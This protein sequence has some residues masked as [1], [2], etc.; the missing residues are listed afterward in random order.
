[1][2]TKI[3]QKEFLNEHIASLSPAKRALLEFKLRQS[4]PKPVAGASI[5]RRTRHSPAPLSF[6]Q[7]RLWFLTQLEPDS[8]A[9]NMSLVRRLSGN[10][11]VAALQQALSEIV[12]RHESLRTRFEDLDGIPQQVIDEPQE[13]S[14]KLVDLTGTAATERMA[15][16]QRLAREELRRPFELSRE[17]GLR[18]QLLRL[19]ETEHILLLTMHHIVSD[20]W[21]LGVLFGEL[22]RL[23]EAYTRNEA[24]PL[25]ELRLQYAD[26][27]VWQREWLEAAELQKQLSYWKEQLAGVSPVELPLDN[28]RPPSPSYRGEKQW[29]RLSPE[30]SRELHALARAEGA[31]LFM[32]MLAA[33]QVLLSRYSGQTDICVGSPIANRNRAQLEDLIGSFVNTLL[34]RTD[35]SGDPG[36]SELLKR[37]Q[38]VALAGYAHQDLPFEKLV[39]ELHPE[40][41]LSRNPLFDVIFAMQN[42]QS[43]AAQMG[44]L[45]LEPWGEGSKTTRM[46]LEVHVSEGKQGLV[47]TFVYATDLFEAE[48][49]ERLIGHYEQLLQ[50]IVID[51][52]QRVSE[53]PLLTSA[54]RTQLLTQWNATAT[55]YPEQGIAQLYEAQAEQHGTAIAVRYGDEKL[56][57]AELNERANQLAHYLREFGVGPERLV[58]IC[59]ER[60]LDMLVGLLGVLKAGGAY[61]PL[62]PSYPADRL[63]YMLKDAQPSLLLTQ[64][65]L[66][67]PL[68]KTGLRTVCLDGD[69]DSIARKPIDNLRSETTLENLAYVM[70]TSGSTG[71]PKGVAVTQRNVVRLVRENNYASLNANEVFLQFAPLTFDASTLEVWGAL[72]NGAQLVVFPPYTPTL[73]ELGGTIEKNKISTLW[74]TAGLFHQLVDE[75]PQSLTGVRQVLAGGDVLSVPHVEKALRF[76]NGNR[77]INGYGPTENTTFTCCHLI[78]S[79]GNRSIPIG[80]PL[81]NTQVYVLDRNYQPVPVGVPGELYV[82]G[83]GLARGYLNRPEL[84]AERFIPDLFSSKPGARLYRTGDLVRYLASGELEFIRRVDQQVKIRG[85]RIEP[86]EIEYALGQHPGVAECVVTTAPAEPGEKF[87]AAYVVAAAGR[88]PE[89]SELRSF[90]QEKLPEYMIPGAFVFLD[91]MPLTPNGKVDQQALPALDKASLPIEQF[92]EPR[93]ATEKTLCY[94][95]AKALRLERVGIFDNF[96]D[97]GGNSLTATRLISRVRSVLNVDLPLRALFESPTI[98]E[99]AQL[100][101]KAESRSGKSYV[102]PT[103]MKIQPLGTRRPIFFVAAPNINALGYVALAD[104]L[105][106]DR[107][108]YGL[109]SQKYIKTK[110]DEY[111]RPLLE[112][113]QAV[114]EELASEYVKAMREVQPHGPYMLGGMCRG[115]HI[116]FE[117]ALQLKAQGETVSLL[118][119]LDTWVME[120]TYSYWFHV[121]YYLRRVPWFLKLGASEKLGFV[122]KKMNGLLNKIAIQLKLRTDPDAHLPRWNEV[123]WPDSS[124]EPKIYDGPITVFRV[125][126]QPATYIRSHTLAWDKRSSCDVH[127]EIVPGTHETILREPS[128]KTLASRLTEIIAKTEATVSK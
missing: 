103:V 34:L 19:S 8:P 51:R 124:F 96:F 35:L 44:G 54:E 33:F 105:G 12:R 108:L 72:L 121:D 104:K 26:F 122:K 23:Y 73:E 111:G 112:F 70:Y 116:A 15:E 84:T 24:S 88:K 39:D 90:L 30:L 120:N 22:Q 99:F 32:V 58:A 101:K 67:S 3:S 55:Q 11:A 125:P 92:V 123:Y 79:S 75:R 60:S 7:E 106:D 47:C 89:T 6:A 83:D 27:A 52:T 100:V 113:S 126:K 76:M 13:C 57:Y 69:R 4:A 48:T 117:M 93:T 95:W 59:V 127:V 81:A 17:W 102:W 110:S 63:I 14:L 94:I 98:A 107:P 97:L 74:L 61:L 85:F 87:L 10:L 16:A 9:Y 20:G 65:K 46:D 56:S 28:P 80:R 31:T 5:P 53:L 86:A 78:K 77:L 128:V 114:V 66:V 71:Y 50:A 18:A 64:T 37:V 29:L 21:S 115:A 40:R 2:T 41:S 68:P 118:A 91:A 49:I 43:S 25:P 62:D 1:M 42:A 45:Q 119:I 82:G 36:F 38:E 109:Q